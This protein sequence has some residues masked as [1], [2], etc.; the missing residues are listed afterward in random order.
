MANQTFGLEMIRKAN[1]S[2]KTD[3]QKQHRH[4]HGREMQGYTQ[5]GSRE[6]GYR[7]LRRTP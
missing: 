4:M 2:R 7:G 6:E 3:S 1:S 5:S